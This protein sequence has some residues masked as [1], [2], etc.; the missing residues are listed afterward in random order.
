[1][2]RPKH[3]EFM[4]QAITSDFEVEQVAEDKNW[5]LFA[6]ERKD[7]FRFVEY[8]TK[9]NQVTQHHIPHLAVARAIETA[10]AGRSELTEEGQ[11][12]VATVQGEISIASRI[13]GEM[14]LVIRGDAVPFSVLRGALDERLKRVAPTLTAARKKIVFENGRYGIPG[15]TTT[16]Q[17]NPLSSVSKDLIEGIAFEQALR[18]RLYGRDFGLYSAFCTHVDFPCALH[19][20][21]C[22]KELL[23]RHF[24]CYGEGF[25]D[26]GLVEVALE[27]Q[28]KL[29]PFPIWGPGIAADSARAIEALQ[30]AVAKLDPVQ[31]T[32]VV[33]L[34]GMH[35]GN[36]FLTMAAVTGIVTFD[37]YK[38]FQTSNLAQASEEEQFLRISTSFI[39]LFGDVAPP[40]PGYAGMSRLGQP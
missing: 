27:V 28:N 21:S 12:Y 16:H 32:Q 7:F 37:K 20:Q 3:T 19:K 31:T 22:I 1:M 6:S 25:P 39:E 35:G 18:R 4:T 33:L 13:G 29:F 26:N 17:D 15:A 36:V 38:E 23:D 24:E 9:G 2:K 40:C 8:D 10:E 11:A 5:I 34:N 30:S 14:F